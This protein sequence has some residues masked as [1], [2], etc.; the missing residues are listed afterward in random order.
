MSENNLT[1]LQESLMERLQ[2]HCDCIRDLSA[3]LYGDLQPKGQA[4][5]D[6]GLGYMEHGK[7]FLIA[8]IGGD[9]TREVPKNE[10]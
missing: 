9:L 4:N 3:Q 7:K 1:P 6:A 5:V 8:G 2:G 10:R